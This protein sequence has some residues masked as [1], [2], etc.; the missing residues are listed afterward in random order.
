M[1]SAALF[2]VAVHSFVDALAGARRAPEPDV[3]PFG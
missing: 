1:G 3:G 2:E